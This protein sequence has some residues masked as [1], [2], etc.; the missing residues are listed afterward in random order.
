[1]NVLY[2]YVAC[3]IA[4][5]PV[6]VSIPIQIDTSNHLQDFITVNECTCTLSTDEVATRGNDEQV[7]RCEQEVERVDQKNRKGTRKRGHQQLEGKS[8]KTRSKGGSTFVW[9]KTL[10]VDAPL[11]PQTK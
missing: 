1:M 6:M 5:T 10:S 4:N 8:Y 2:Q 3:L 7:E 9:S 11:E